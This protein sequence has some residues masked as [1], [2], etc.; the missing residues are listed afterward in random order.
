MRIRPVTPTAALAFACLAGLASTA[1]AAPP[2]RRPYTSDFRLA[3]CTFQTTGTNPYFPL[4]V[5][6]RLL[7]ENEDG[8]ETVEITVLDETEVI[9]VPGLGAVTTR[10][11]QERETLDGDVIEISR[12]FFAVCGGRG[13]VVY[14]GEDVDIFHPDGSITHDGAWRAGQPDANGLAAPG[15]IMPGT[16]LL[17]SRYF[18]ELADGIA[19]DRAENAEMGITIDTEAGTFTDCVRVVETSPLERKSES[20]KIYCPGVGLVVDSDLELVEYE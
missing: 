10:V 19:L 12:N 1:L 3:D 2:D 15:I 13:D 11:I 6:H 4:V 14:F 9:T 8:S 7:L 5:G 17:G 18:Q 16:F 20:V